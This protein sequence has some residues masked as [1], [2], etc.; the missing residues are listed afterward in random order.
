MNTTKN[1]G[2]IECGRAAQKPLYISP[3]SILQGYSIKKRYFPKRS[4]EWIFRLRNSRN[5]P[6]Y[7]GGCSRKDYKKN[8]KVK[9]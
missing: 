1:I 3:L 9:H 2:L 4:L 7:G 8:Y 6:E 5:V